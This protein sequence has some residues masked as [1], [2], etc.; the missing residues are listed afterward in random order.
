LIVY[1]KN[2]GRRTDT[3]DVALRVNAIKRLALF[4]QEYRAAF[5]RWRRGLRDVLF[6]F[7]TYALRRFAAVPCTAG[8][9]P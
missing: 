1:V 3:K 4:L 2:A 8:P 7:G 6:P 9:A 5:S